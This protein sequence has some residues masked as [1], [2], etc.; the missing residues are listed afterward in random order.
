M[1]RW[2][3]RT[4]SPTARCCAPCR[5]APR[6]LRADP[7]G[8]RTAKKLTNPQAGLAFEL[9]A[10]DSQSVTQPPAPRFDSAQTAAEMGELYWMAL[11]RDVAFINY[12]TDAAA[13][14]ASSTAPSARSTASSPRS[15]AP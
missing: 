3:T 5:T 6:G 13:A 14:A 12:A 11:A 4:P 1:T 8:V 2:E 10:P 7:P 9:E 15:V